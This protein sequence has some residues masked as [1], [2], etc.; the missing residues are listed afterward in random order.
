MKVNKQID[1]V[2]INCVPKDASELDRTTASV[3]QIPAIPCTEIAPTTSSIFNLSKRNGEHNDYAPIAPIIVA[4]PSDGISGSAV[5][6]TS[7]QEHHL[8]PC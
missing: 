6:D 8:T 3:P 2:P 4:N 7:Q 5:I 1:T